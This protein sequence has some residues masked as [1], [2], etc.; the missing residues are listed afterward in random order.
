MVHA[1]PDPPARSG[2]PEP[3]NILGPLTDSA[4]FVTLAI[5]R[6]GGAAAVR[7]ALPHLA[8]IIRPAG[9]GAPTG[10]LGIGSAAWDRL[11]PGPRP[12]RLRPFRESA[13]VTAAQGDLFLHL[14][15]QLPFS[16]FE[17]ARHV[18]GVL[19]D[20]VAVVDRVNGFRYGCPRNPEP[21][22]AALVGPGDD[23]R[24]AGGSYLHVRKHVHDF[25]RWR[26]LPAAERDRLAG[27]RRLDSVAFEP[28][29]G[30]VRDRMP[31]AS[32]TNG[33]YG[34]LVV[35]YA[36][37]PAVTGLTDRPLEVSTVVTGAL[38]FVPPMAFLT[39]KG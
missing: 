2:T 26:A 22:D 38:Y 8:G 33:E 30:I 6:P 31:F 10:V 19:G 11:L 28:E 35:T 4:L 20:A 3:Q 23:P 16:C 32:I 36:A 27:G 7:E 39:G 15:A 1:V 25:D 37:D 29:P 9:P 24:F 34:A 17:L 18:S 5:R 13:G 21:A 12:A 14:R